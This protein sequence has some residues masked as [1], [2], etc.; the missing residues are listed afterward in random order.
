MLHEPINQ[1]AWFAGLLIQAHAVIPPILFCQA[2]FWFS[3]GC[4]IGSPSCDGN[5]GQLVPC[6][7]HKYV[8]NG[9]KGTQP[10]PFGQC[11]EHGCIVVNP[12]AQLPDPFDPAM[13]P[14]GAVG[15]K[16]TLCSSDL[17]TVNTHAE[18]GSKH[19][20]WQFAPWRAP[21]SVPV[22]DSWCDHNLAHAIPLHA[23]IYS[24]S[25]YYCPAYHRVQWRRRWEASRP[26]PGNCRCRLC[27]H[28]AR[29]VG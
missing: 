26:G 9:T 1:R 11:N 25:A 18:C 13:R 10:P 6:C 21:G 20:F 23:E 17:R 24:T 12:A 8:W 22:L 2:C 16:P 7:T 19:D 5:S 14:K 28:H 3:N 29:Q 15:G 4:G 27:E